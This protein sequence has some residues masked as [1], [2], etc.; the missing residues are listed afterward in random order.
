MAV[1]ELGLQ[2]RV[3]VEEATLRDPASV[4]LPFNPVGRVPTLVLAD[5]TTITETTPVADD[6]GCAGAAG[7]AACCRA[8]TDRARWQPMAGCWA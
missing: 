1:I 4:L 7:P 2:D 6:A 8:R 3:A 5:G